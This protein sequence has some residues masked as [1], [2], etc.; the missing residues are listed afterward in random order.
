MMQWKGKITPGSRFL[1]PVSAM[2]IFTTSLN[3]SGIKSTQL[4]GIDGVD[5]M[6]YLSRKIDSDPHDRL[7]WR[8]DHVRAIRYKKWKLILST[9]DNWLELYNMENDKSETINLTDLN[10]IERE[11]LLA[12]FEEW[13]KDLPQKPLWPRI[14]DRK[15]VI[16]DRIYYFPA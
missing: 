13:N 2:D 15:F 8:A 9:R 14:M 6:P 1:A 12:Y 11:N 10:P 16:G 7:Y 4:T 3:A 5:L